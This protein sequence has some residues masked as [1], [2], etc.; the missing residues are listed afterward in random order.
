MVL[1]SQ[2]VVFLLEL[3]KF[4]VALML[5]FSLWKRVKY[6]FLF[7]SCAAGGWNRLEGDFNLNSILVK[8]LPDNKL[9]EQAWPTCRNCKIYHYLV[10]S[11]LHTNSPFHKGL[12]KLYHFES[13]EGHSGLIFFYSLNS[14]LTELQRSKR[15]LPYIAQWSFPK[16]KTF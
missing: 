15:K 16:L 9:Q 14:E 4:F 3:D 12:N 2:N 13:F 10:Y 6:W 8:C 7:C 11:N 1:W 5:L